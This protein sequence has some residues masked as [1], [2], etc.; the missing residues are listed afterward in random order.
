MRP[1]KL[2]RTSSFRL[3]LIYAAL[4]LGSA[5]LLFA[6][7]Y[8]ST[9]EYMTDQLDGAIV[10]EIDDI[11]A[12]WRAGGP[13]SLIRVVNDRIAHERAGEIA[14]ML[15]ASDGTVLAGNM[16]AVV[17]RVDGQDIELPVAHG[18]GRPR[19]M[20][21]R[22]AF[23]DNGDFL[24]VGKDAFALNEMRET[25]AR[26]FGLI[27]AATLG[28]AL[29]GGLVMSRGLLR[30]IEGLSRTTLGILNGDLSRRAPIRGAD[31]EFD[32]LAAGL[33]AML[34][35]IQSLMEA[36]SQVSNDI[37]HDLRT[38]LTRLR[39][40]LE[41]A[42]HKAR[43]V[44]ELQAALDRSIDDTDAIL[45]TFAGL[46]NI[47]QIESGA[48]RL[49]FTPVNL[50]E[51]L[52]TVVELHEPTAHDKGQRF[53]VSIEPGLVVSGH[54]QL[55]A[56][57]LSNLIENAIRH[58]PGGAAI[59]VAALRRGGGIEVAV[60]DNGPGIPEDERTKVF[61]RFYRLERSRTTPG[62]G[63]GL[64]L[65]AAVA[66][67]HDVSVVLGH[68]A[69]GLTVTLRFPPPPGAQAPTAAPRRSERVM[70][71]ETKQC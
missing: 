4:F 56:Q 66:Q 27:I 1:P 70:W 14:Y 25:I 45:D 51:L 49:S 6:V 16:P 34:D 23:L 8:W 20:R 53:A 5:C 59:G 24:A 13:D 33:N 18:A 10:D 2:L 29:A 3:T 36:M 39:Q 11:Q 22:G 63:L 48:Q 31:D 52:G 41:L 38:P 15:E 55:L 37:A 17:A 19:H 28:L 21:V 65:V 58:S 42:R 44:E 47:A 69:P 9:V 54:R 67:L 35:R 61:R 26:S 46:L 32:H 62:N 68:N 30:N 7:I 64:S 43:T 71:R 50:S 57:M 60:S 40:R 12:D